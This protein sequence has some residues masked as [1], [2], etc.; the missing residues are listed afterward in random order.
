MHPLFTRTS[1]IVLTLSLTVLSTTA[2]SQEACTFGEATQ[3]AIQSLCP[4]HEGMAR[5]QINDQWG[6][7]NRSGSLV[8]PPQ[9]DEVHDFSSGLAAARQNEQWGFIDPQGNWVIAPTWSNV[10]PF[11]DGLAAVEQNDRWGYIDRTGAQ[12]I[13]PTYRNAGD[14]INNVSIVSQ[15][16]QKDLMINKNGQV[17]H[18]FQPNT[19]VSNNPNEFGLF[20]I[21]QGT[22]NTLHHIDGRTLQPTQESEANTYRNG[23]FVASKHIENADGTSTDLKGIID[24]QNQWIIP[25]QYQEL[26][27][28]ENGLAIATLPNP[29]NQDTEEED[30]EQKTDARVILINQ[31]G[32]TVYGPARSIEYHKES[33]Y[34]EVTHQFDPREQTWLNQQGKPLFPST[35]THFENTPTPSTSPSWTVFTGCDET[36]VLF[37]NGSVARSE[38]GKPTI[39]AT[40]K[41][42]LLSAESKNRFIGLQFELFDHSGKKVFSTSDL[43]ENLRKQ[44]NHVMLLQPRGAVSQNSG[45]DLP[46]LLLK[47]R[48]NTQVGIV[49]PQYQFVSNPQWTYTDNLEH[50]T[51]SY[52]SDHETVEGP[53]RMHTKQGYG[54]IDSQGNWVVQPIYNAMS[55]FENG[56]TYAENGEAHFVVQH[57]GLAHPLPERTYNLEIR[58]ASVI[59]WRNS[60]NQIIRKNLDTGEQMINPY[61]KHPNIGQAHQGLQPVEKNNLWGLQND[62]GEWVVPPTYTQQITPIVHNGL[63]KAWKTNEEINT[64][65]SSDDLEGLLSPEGQVIS[66]PL[67]TEIQFD[68]NTE[69]WRVQIQDRQGLMKKDGRMFLEPIYT[70]ITNLGNGWF[71]ATSPEQQG[72]INNTGELVV[73]LSD[74]DWSGLRNRPYLVQQNGAKTVLLGIDG[75]TSTQQKPGSLPKEPSTWWWPV[76]HRDKNYNHW[77]SF[78][79]FDFKKKIKVPGEVPSY[80]RFS[81]GVTAFSPNK[82]QKGAGIGLIDDKGRVLGVYPYHEIEPMKEGM[83]KVSREVPSKQSEDEYRYNPPM[84]Y[85]YL[86]RQGKLAIPFRYQSA[87]DFTEQRATVLYRDQIG[88]ID[89]KGTML[90]SGA[91]ICDHAVLVN[92][93]KQ[94]IWPNL[95]EQEKSCPI[96]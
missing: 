86:N 41:H 92:S 45:H 66:P 79:G 13:A 84:Q 76:N 23:F 37:A 59:E 26:S 49:T 68:E 25:A 54:A 27:A 8:I 40:T 57:N 73:G 28:L 53:L 78:Y 31:Q 18:T 89:Q 42:L 56:L 32:K 67:Y 38:V 36:W 62:R 64:P 63:L 2:F 75:Q 70:D 74:H 81:E 60:N 16:Y 12:V 22:T 48:R 6:F 7:V 88:L 24:A 51:R 43:S 93:K 80:A 39:S 34:Y 91:W 29:T 17:I 95:S 94:I 1:R 21:S 5:I 96:N 46:I 9:F 65:E 44:Y 33:G 83:A 3:T 61:G 20:E 77:S 85:G 58:S 19:S 10:R 14:F 72:L 87:T 11:S 50:Y 4:M 47:D 15:G 82:P 52:F 71:N 55:V 90:L 30:D 35:C 69:M